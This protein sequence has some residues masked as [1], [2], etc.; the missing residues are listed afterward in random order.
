MGL[1]GC[2]LQ[3]AD[4]LFTRRASLSGAKAGVRLCA[5]TA[6]GRPAP[7]VGRGA[8]AGR[9]AGDRV[10]EEQLNESGDGEVVHDIPCRWYSR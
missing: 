4:I 7:R 1:V 3:T 2:A 8:S 10:R 6:R 9:G 5:A